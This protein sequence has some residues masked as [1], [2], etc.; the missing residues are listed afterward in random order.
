MQS[1]DSIYELILGQIREKHL[2][3][4]LRSLIKLHMKQWG[5]LN[6][7]MNALTDILSKLHTF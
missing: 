1:P 4:L 3:S 5:L 2:S 7:Q 6:S